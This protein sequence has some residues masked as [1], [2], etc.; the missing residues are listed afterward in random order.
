MSWPVPDREPQL[1]SQTRMRLVRVAAAA[2]VRVVPARPGPGASLPRRS[3]PARRTTVPVTNES[4]CLMIANT[5]A[6]AGARPQPASRRPWPAAVRPNRHGGVTPVQCCASLSTVSD[7][8]RPATRRR[9]SLT[10]T[11]TQL[12]DSQWPYRH[13]GDHDCRACTIRVMRPL[14]VLE[15]L[16]SVPSRRLGITVNLGPA[17]LAPDPGS[18]AESRPA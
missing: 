3:G 2:S 9:C 18:E 15:E 5:A 11:R 14:G 10:R 1:L 4:P 16:C 13:A 8:P 7:R 17:P 12:S 6:H